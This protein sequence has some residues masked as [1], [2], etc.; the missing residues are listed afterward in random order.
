MLCA[1]YC[2]NMAVFAQLAGQEA[3]QA[4]PWMNKWT[5]PFK[6]SIHLAGHL[7]PKGSGR[8]Y[9]TFHSQSLLSWKRLGAAT[10]RQCMY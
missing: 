8:T 10:R 7:H 4:H 1:A 5:N 3:K 6:D 2:L 9:M